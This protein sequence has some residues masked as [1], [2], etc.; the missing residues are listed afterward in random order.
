LALTVQAQG[1]FSAYLEF[2]VIYY[3][4]HSYNETHVDFGLKIEVINNARY[5]DFVYKRSF[6]LKNSSGHFFP[7]QT[8][9]SFKLYPSE[10]EKFT[11]NFTIP[12]EMVVEN[13]HYESPDGN[14]K[15]EFPLIPEDE[16]RGSRRELG[17]L[18]II[19]IVIIGVVFLI[20]LGL[21][22]LTTSYFKRKKRRG[23]FLKY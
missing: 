8:T 19:M 16:G 7:S 20:V 5:N 1:S 6:Y 9:G 11:I 4:I 22:Y 21:I 3:E 18:D 12:N 10:S 23:R 17:T 14:K 15:Y 13:I 2:E